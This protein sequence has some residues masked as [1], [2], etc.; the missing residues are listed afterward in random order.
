[1]Q[2]YIRINNLVFVKYLFDWNFTKDVMNLKKKI[3]FHHCKKCYSIIKYQMF[4]SEFK[5]LSLTQILIKWS[6]YFFLLE[7]S[8]G[9]GMKFFP[10][11]RLWLSKPMGVENISFHPSNK[12]LIK[13]LEERIFLLR[14]GYFLL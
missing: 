6:F 10:S 7:G 12:N 9:R 2:L 5:I 4:L 14:F 3:N 1:M 11:L 8:I 13:F